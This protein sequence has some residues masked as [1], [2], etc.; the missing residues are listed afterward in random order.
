MYRVVGRLGYESD[1]SL[2]FDLAFGRSRRQPRNSAGP[3]VRQRL[4]SPNS[5]PRAEALTKISIAWTASS[6]AREALRSA[7]AEGLVALALSRTS[8]DRFLAF[9]RRTAHPLFGRDLGTRFSAI[10]IESLSRNP[11]VYLDTGSSAWFVSFNL[12]LS[13][14]VLT[15]AECQRPN[16][17]RRRQKKTTSLIPA[18]W[19]QRVSD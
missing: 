2:I 8:A 17:R 10:D 4:H 5:V 7:L 9:T 6:N 3:S 13:T 11:I 14:H 18:S 16:W 12:C 1:A 15:S 19:V